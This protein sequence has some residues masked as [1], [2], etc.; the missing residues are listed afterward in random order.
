M[1]PGVSLPSPSRRAMPAA[2]TSE[3]PRRR[4]SSRVTPRPGETGRP[5]AA[6]TAYLVPSSLTAPPPMLRLAILAG[7]FLGGM[8]LLSV[9]VGDGRAVWDHPALARAA[10]RRRRPPDRPARPGPAGGAGP[11]RR[12]AG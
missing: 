6:V 12:R 2:A 5:A 3:V 4:A 7:F 11:P 8:A 9:L 1:R 10:E